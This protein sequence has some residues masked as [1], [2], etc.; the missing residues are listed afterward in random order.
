MLYSTFDPKKDAK[1]AYLYLNKAVLLGVTFFDNMTNFF[2]ENF[3]VL[4]P[5]F[6]ELRQ[7]PKEMTSRQQIEN[8]HEA[9]INELSET[10]MSK[11]GK[12]RL[13]ERSCGFVTDQ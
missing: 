1:K 11:L 7:A 5:V 9:Y 8:L 13:Y 4:A 3:D 10:F 12:D 2:K 6:C